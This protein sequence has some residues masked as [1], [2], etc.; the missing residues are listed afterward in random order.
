MKKI[1]T[2]MALLV[3]STLT[4]AGKP[5]QVKKGNLDFLKDDAIAKVEMDYSQTTWEKDRAYD[6]FC[7][8]DYEPRVAQSKE[9]FI[10]G[11]N[12]KSESLKLTDDDDQV[13]YTIT[14]HVGDLE[15]KM[16]DIAMFYIRIVGSITVV[17]N[18]TGEEVC[19]IEIDKLKGYSSYVPDT[20]L[21]SCF[22]TLGQNFAKLKK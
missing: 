17:D 14:V 2:I 7:G 9:A 15:R 3:I 16:F 8:E 10:Q 4:F 12:S 18:E 6:E 22:L 20:R 21:Y 13:K 1:V 11:F 19:T 5:L